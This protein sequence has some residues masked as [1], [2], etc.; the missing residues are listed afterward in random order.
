MERGN[1]RGSVLILAIFVA[2][3]VLSLTVVSL[4]ST[5]AHATSQRG[6]RSVLIAKQIADSGAAQALAKLKEGG[7]TVPRSGSGSSP[8]WVDFGE[9]QFYYYSVADSVN[10]IITIRSWGRV[11][12]D[13]NPSSSSAAP[14][15]SGWDGDGWMTKGV[16]IIARNVKFIPDTPMYFGNGGVERPMGGFA[17]TGGADPFD[18]TTWG[19]VTS[20]V[21]SWQDSSVPFTASALDHP[22]D[23]LYG[24]TSTPTPAVAGSMFPYKIWTSQNP[25]GQFNVQ[26][27]FDNSA[28]SSSDP[29][30]TSQPPPSSDYFDMSDP[31]SPDHAYPVDPSIPDVQNFAWELW[32]TYGDGSGGGTELSQGNRYGTYGD[33]SN[34]GVTFVTGRLTVPPGETFRG[35][36]ILVIRDDYDPNED[37]DNTPWI[38]AGLRVRG[39]FEWTG[40]VVVAGWAPE[41]VVDSGASATVVGAMFG[42]DSVQSGGEVS[43]DSAT[44]ILKIQDEFNLLYSNSLFQPGGIVHQFMPGVDK[45]VI[46]VREIQ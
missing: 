18:P 22:I 44:I 42:E 25:I 23:F 30:S 7:F 15:E 14:D 37:T 1:Q 11:A 12:V 19:T 26:A 38:K 29:T 16:E 33:L 34:P 6:T 17:W 10:G 9:G 32:S 45:E 36:G 5:R 39:N 24:G 40:L 2:L 3:G 35:A 43:L 13:A 8:Q 20:G 31:T 41:I 21:S 46:G 28:G 4:D 27:W